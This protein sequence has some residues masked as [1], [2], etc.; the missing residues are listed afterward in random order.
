[1]ARSFN[2]DK[3]F[4]A[5]NS[6]PRAI[7]RELLSRYVHRYTMDHKPAWVRN[8]R[9]D[10]RPYM[11]QYASDAEWLAKTYFNVKANG[12]P[13]NADCYSATPT[14]PLGKG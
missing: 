10:G 6:F 8:P 2:H 1:M 13:A 9:P 5:G 12:T 14:W 7:Q 4:V 11:P 3:P